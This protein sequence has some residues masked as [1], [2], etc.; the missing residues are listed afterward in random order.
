MLRGS[1]SFAL[2]FPLA[3]P[4]VKDEQHVDGA[5]QTLVLNGA[6]IARTILSA[7]FHADL[8]IQRLI[9]I[10]PAIRGRVVVIERLLDL[11]F[12][13]CAVVAAPRN[14]SDSPSEQSFLKHLGLPVKQAIAGRQGR[15]AAQADMPCTADPT[16][17]QRWR[18]GNGAGFITKLSGLSLKS[19]WDSRAQQLHADAPYS[20]PSR[21][22]S[23]VHIL[24]LPGRL[25]RIPATGPGTPG[26]AP[27]IVHA[28]GRLAVLDRRHAHGPDHIAQL[29]RN[30]HMG[31]ALVLA[32][33]LAQG[34]RLAHLRIGE[35]PALRLPDRCLALGL[36]IA[37]VENS[38]AHGL[39]FTTTE[40]RL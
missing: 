4:F 1:G 20:R 30:H 38:N 40:P 16:L 9:Q 34:Q 19:R 36:G 10:G 18:P 11:G 8:F 2:E 3:V 27:L 21:P 33:L 25:G 13:R 31:M 39:I 12:A 28:I 5:S 7:V 37:Q 6:A 14:G 35:G 26:L 22:G 23:A 24:A 17:P 32:Q 29:R 15:Q